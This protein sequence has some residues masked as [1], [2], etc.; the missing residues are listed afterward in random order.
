MSVEPGGVRAQKALETAQA[1]KEAGRR[2]FSRRGFLDAK[3]ADIAAEAGRSVG[4]FYKHF[5]GKEELLRALLVEWT[6]QAGQHLQDDP[7]GDDLSEPA[8]LRA[9]VA[10]YVTVYREHLPEI[11][12]LGEAAITDRAFAEQVAATRHEQ[13]TTMRALLTRLHDRGFELAGDPAVV[14]S[15][16]N[17]LLEGFCSLWIGGRGEPLGRTLSDDEAID[18]LTAILASGIAR[19]PVDVAD[20]DGA[21]ESTSAKGPDRRRRG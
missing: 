6:E 15:A 19:R 11:R 14:A 5:T 17:A 18:T 4:S 2:V 10:A 12:A 3:V 8:A 21:A 7:V 9:R 16:F 20:K 1:L 13:L